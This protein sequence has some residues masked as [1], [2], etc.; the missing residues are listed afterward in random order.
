[1]I[2]LGLVV[3]A[4]LRGSLEHCRVSII[5][6]KKRTS[7]PENTEK[8][9]CRSSEGCHGPL[10]LWELLCLSVAARCLCCRSTKLRRQLRERAWPDGVRAEPWAVTKPGHVFDCSRASVN[11]TLFENRLQS[12]ID[13]LQISF[14]LGGGGK[15]AQLNGFFG[16]H[17]ARHKSYNLYFQG[18]FSEL[19]ES[20]KQ[21]RTYP[22]AKQK[23]NFLR[24]RKVLWSRTH[25]L[26]CSLDQCYFPLQESWVVQW[27]RKAWRDTWAHCWVNWLENTKNKLKNSQKWL[28]H[29][30]QWEH[31][32]VPRSP[33]GVR[34][35]NSQC[36]DAEGF[37]EFPSHCGIWLRRNQQS[38][39]QARASQS[40]IEVQFL[41]LSA[42]KCVKL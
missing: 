19:T 1:M 20:L 27:S 35:S 14:I 39:C 21:A 23:Q 10:P 16:V 2:A 34:E 36:H 26:P 31:K 3:S 22:F 41:Y 6:C 24:D 11:Q 13:S 40:H 4:G 38:V 42:L 17:F 12:C 15:E 7:F 9:C 37:A 18:S 28:L 5:A 32:G 25:C 8:S 29:L 33:R 30:C